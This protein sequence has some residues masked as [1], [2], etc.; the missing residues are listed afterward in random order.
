MPKY[1]LGEASS[2]VKESFKGD[3]SGVP[4]VGLEHLIPDEV[5]LSAWAKDADNTFTKTFMQGDMLFGRRR[6][7][8]RKAALAPFSGICSGDITVIRA[9][10]DIL[11]PNL[12]P[13]IIQSEH[14]FDF[15]V[16]KSAGSL[17]P[18]V[19]WEH[20]KMYELML[21]SLAEQEKVAEVLWSIEDTC[22]AYKKLLVETDELVKSQFIE[23]FG[24][25]V[26][27]I[28]KYDTV[29]LDEV[30]DKPQGGEWG[31]DDDAGTGTP[32]LRTTNFTDGGYVDYSDV[33]TRIIDAK[34][35]EKKALLSGDILIEKSGGSNDKPV[36]RVVFFEGESGKYLNNNFTARL[37]LNGRYNLGKLYTFFFMFVNY[38][39]D[40]TRLYEG[41]TTG[42]HNLHLTEYLQ[43]T[44]IPLAPVDA[45]ERFEQFARQSD[46]SR[47]ALQQSLKEARALQK[48]IVEENFIPGKEK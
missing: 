44:R 13:F 23:K 14:L 37:H 48:K 8:L 47:F 29:P 18:R 45:Q 24:D 21:P 6:A 9:N 10:Q 34:K 40:G 38:W 20:L 22:Q 27:E 43:N 46:K 33:A 3:K 36:G 12:L 7:Y 19:K 25:T 31:T 4:I 35:V 1:I 26:S 11:S 32:V 41:K 16:G 42:I 2:E 15:A 39:A 5:T 28:Q 17:S 30:F